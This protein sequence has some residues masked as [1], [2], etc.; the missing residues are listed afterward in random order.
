[1]TCPARFSHH[2]RQE[3]VA[4]VDHALEVDPDHP[5]PVLQRGVQETAAETDPGVVHQNVDGLDLGMHR[6]CK[7]RHIV[8]RGDV[9]LLSNHLAPHRLELLRK[10]LEPLFV[11]V[12]DRQIRAAPSK[13]E[14]RLATDAAGRTGNDR[15]LPAEIGY[16]HAPSV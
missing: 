12:A 16:I 5:V 6:R 9:D 11:E 1:M 14:S 4:A 7:T 15:H 2:R 3:K 13:L 10:S 8:D